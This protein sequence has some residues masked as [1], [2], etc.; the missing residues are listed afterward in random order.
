MKVD[1]LDHFVLTVKDVEA[2]CAFYVNVLG[3]EEASFGTGRKSLVF[4]KAKINLH[5]YGHEYEPKAGQPTPGSADLCFV[6]EVTIAEVI[7]H[8]RSLAVKIE[9]GP[10]KRI[11]AFGEIVSVYIRDPDKNL[12][13][14]SNDIER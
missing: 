12:I 14:I 4:G 6:T 10:V 13:E 8:V 9:E 3:M 1:R 7:E 11:G 2:T 5:E